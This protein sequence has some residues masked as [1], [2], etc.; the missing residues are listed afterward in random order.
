M[1]KRSI[2]LV[3]E[4]EPEAISVSPKRKNFLG[5]IPLEIVLMHTENGLTPRDLILALGNFLNRG[6]LLD[7]RML[8]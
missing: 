5:N 1:Y 2:K 6:L 4:S 3:P 8:L 7:V